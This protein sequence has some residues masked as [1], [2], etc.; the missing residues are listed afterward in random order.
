MSVTGD[1]RVFRNRS[2][3]RAI[4][5]YDSNGAVLN[6][7]GKTLYFTVKRVVDTDN[8]DA[9]AVIKKTITSHSNPTQ[10]VT[11]VTILNTDTASLAPG[12][13]FFD[14]QY[15]SAKTPSGNGNFYIDVPILLE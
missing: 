9:L 13:Y 12:R 2:I 15:D 8:T 5:V 7:T 4:T 6:I 10:G 14:I 3:T 11:S 1:F